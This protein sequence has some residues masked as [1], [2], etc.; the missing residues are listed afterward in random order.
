MTP[1]QRKVIIRAAWRKMVKEADYAVPIHDKPHTRLAVVLISRC[2]FPD[3]PE[4]R[5]MIAKIFHAAERFGLDTGAIRKV[6]PWL[7]N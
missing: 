4:V 3:L 6:H 2:E 7:V 1:S 5:V